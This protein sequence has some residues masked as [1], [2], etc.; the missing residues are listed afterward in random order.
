MKAMR[1]QEE[2]AAWKTSEELEYNLMNKY[3]DSEDKWRKN[4]GQDLYKDKASILSVD[5]S[6][7][8]KINTMTTENQITRD[9]SSGISELLFKDGKGH[10]HDS[11]KQG[12][13][14]NEKI[15]YGIH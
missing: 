5:A 13:Y 10:L 14:F 1:E 2:S 9:E 6:S 8:Q 7:R 11:W 3:M 15:K 12:F 4:L